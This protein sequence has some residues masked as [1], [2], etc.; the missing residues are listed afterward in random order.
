MGQ[1]VKKC[2]D[3]SRSKVKIVWWKCW[4]RLEQEASSEGDKC[5]QMVNSA[6]S[7]WNVASILCVYP[8]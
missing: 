2:N 1:R 8:Y 6:S 5:E 3:Q 4:L 7:E